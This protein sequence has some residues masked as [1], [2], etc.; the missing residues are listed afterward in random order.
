MTNISLRFQFLAG[1]FIFCLF[2]SETS[3][4]LLPVPELPSNNPSFYLVVA[5]SGSQMLVENEDAHKDEKRRK[6]G[7]LLLLPADSGKKEDKEGKKCMT[8]CNRW[9]QDCIIDPAKG[10]QCRR[11]C[12]EFGEECF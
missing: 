7:S 8:V 2:L 3:L 4:A 10:R 6:S 1:A 9:G 5:T 11:T 12:K